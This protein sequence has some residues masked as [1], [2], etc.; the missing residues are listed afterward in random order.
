MQTGSWTGLNGDVTGD[1]D[2]M[3]GVIFDPLQEW[4][5]WSSVFC[6]VRLI[7]SSGPET[8]I[9]HHAHIHTEARQCG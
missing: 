1:N 9:T 5:S 8:H 2:K 4:Q 6:Q 7:V 3:I